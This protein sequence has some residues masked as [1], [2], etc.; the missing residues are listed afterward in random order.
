MR[1]ITRITYIDIDTGEV[2]DIRPTD[3]TRE[4]NF[5]KRKDKTI[6][7]DDLCTII[8]IYEGT[9]K[10]QLE[11]QFDNIINIYK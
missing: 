5:V 10:K 9:K 2:L 8:Y 6:I 11:I 4:Y 3:F 7:K 1:F